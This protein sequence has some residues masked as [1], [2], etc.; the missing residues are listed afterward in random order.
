MYT[1]QAQS[2]GHATT[3]SHLQ[4]DQKQVYDVILDTCTVNRWPQ[5]IAA[6]RPCN[7]FN[8]PQR[9]QPAPGGSKSIDSN[10]WY[11]GI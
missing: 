11:R 1:L 6:P 4:I 8:T 10:T 7:I 2:T 3:S 9:V 5:N